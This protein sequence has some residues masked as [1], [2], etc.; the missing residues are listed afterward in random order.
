MFE[1]DPWLD[2]GIEAEDYVPTLRPRR[3]WFEY[4]GVEPHRASAM[5]PDTPYERTPPFRNLED[6]V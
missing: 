5:A 3:P 6:P 1:D 4:A 2:A